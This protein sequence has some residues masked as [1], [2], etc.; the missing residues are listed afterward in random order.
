MKQINPIKAF[1]RRGNK[2]NI[3]KSYFIYLKEVNYNYYYYTLT[4]KLNN[5][6]Y[7]YIYSSY[8]PRL[9]KSY[10][11]INNINNKSII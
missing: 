6:L 8:T 10:K 1:T 5:T 3:I 2:D 4:F 9:S 11:T 7:Y